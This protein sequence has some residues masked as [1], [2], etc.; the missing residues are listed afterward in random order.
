RLVA[1]TFLR[2]SLRL[3]KPY[4]D[5]YL[6]HVGATLFS[7]K[8]STLKQ[9]CRRF[10]I[11]SLGAI[12][13]Q[14]IYKRRWHCFRVRIALKCPDTIFRRFSKKRGC[15][16]CTEIVNNIPW[17]GLNSFFKYFQCSGEIVLHSQQRQAQAGL[18]S[19]EFRVQLARQLPCP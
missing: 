1:L 8:E 2:E 7:A 9:W 19:G 4:L 13:R 6:A 10:G 11:S 16:T 17:I 18:R 15:R 14:F 3:Q 5:P 12:Q